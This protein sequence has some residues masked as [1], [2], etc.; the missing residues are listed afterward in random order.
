MVSTHSTHDSRKINSRIE[1]RMIR[2]SLIRWRTV[3]RYKHQTPIKNILL[4]ILR[5]IVNDEVCDVYEFFGTTNKQ[6]D[7]LQVDST[8]FTIWMKKIAADDDDN[9]KKIYTSGTVGS[10]IGL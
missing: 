9:S 4:F 1:F 5:V 10:I 2:D 7:P 8:L 6:C 3:L